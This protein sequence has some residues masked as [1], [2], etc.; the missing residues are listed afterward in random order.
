MITRVDVR[1][2]RKNAYRSRYF[3]MNR[4]QREIIIRK[5]S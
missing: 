5:N 4:N 2:E 3:K 1:E